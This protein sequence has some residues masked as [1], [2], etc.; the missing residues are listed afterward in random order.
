MVLPRSRQGQVVLPALLA[1]GQ[2]AMPA[3]PFVQDDI[4]EHVLGHRVSEGPAGVGEEVIA[5][6]SGLSNV[7]TPA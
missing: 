1:L 5:A 3:P 2:V 6:R 4:A 7:S